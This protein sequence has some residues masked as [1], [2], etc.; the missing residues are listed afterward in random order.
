MKKKNYL[1]IYTLTILFV[2]II[3]TSNCEKDDPAVNQTENGTVSDIDGNVYKTVKIGTQV[4]MAENLKT[5]KYRNGDVIPEVTDNDEWGKLSTGACCTNNNDADNV[6]IYGR[7]YNWY[8]ASDS[9]KIA[10]AGWHVSTYD[11]WET[12]TNYLGGFDVAGGKLKETDTIHWKSPNTGATDEVG[13]CAL[14]GGGRYFLRG[15]DF[16]SVGYGGTWWASGTIG[17]IEAWTWYIVNWETAI[18]VDYLISGKQDG[19]SVRCVKD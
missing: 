9:R 2:C 8:A 3:T 19:L 10:P 18:E 14:P 16:T 17:G 11:D 5:T 7:L 1:F 15:F 4:W 6:A 13:F 12:L